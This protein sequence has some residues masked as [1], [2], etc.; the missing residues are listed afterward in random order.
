MDAVPPLWLKKPTGRPPVD[1]K[2]KILAV[3]IKTWHKQGYREA[4][5]YIDENWETCAKHGIVQV[6]DH[7]T[8]WRTLRSLPETYLKRL[9]KKI[10]RF[11]SLGR[12]IAADATGVGT[13]SFKRWVTV[14]AGRK[15]S[16]RDY[17][18]LHAIFQLPELNIPNM[19]VT[20]GEA[21]DSPILKRL[22]REL[23]LD[24][25]EAAAMD[26]GY[27]SRRNCT[28]LAEYGVRS[29]LIKPKK[30]TTANSHGSK[31]W[32]NMILAYRENKEEWIR[33]Y[34]SIRPLA[35]SG[36]SAFKRTMGHWLTS[37]KRCMQRKELITRVLVYNLRIAA[38]T[39]LTEF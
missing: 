8:I 20:D 5:V 18:K 9:N 11:L 2:T 23:P 16:K 14:R 10:N 19:E 26:S 3:M 30:N 37:L 6:P 36:F 39:S 22:M 24:D 38:R 7:V 1:F 13:R 12:R 29:I 15:A 4:E 25:I 17:L 34:N 21:N 33:R 31:A 28:M 35:E 27:L 32:R